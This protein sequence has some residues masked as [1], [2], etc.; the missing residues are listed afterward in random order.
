[1]NRWVGIWLRAWR[2]EPLAF[3]SPLS[4]EVA[5]A[6]LIEGRISH[7]RAAFSFGGG[8]GFT[9]AG[10]VGARRISVQAAKAGIR[11][12]WRPVFRGRLDPTAE[13]GIPGYRPWQQNDS[14]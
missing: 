13:A 12:S 8:G 1:M 14:R 4:A 11:N 9:V 10:H 2:S 7:L 6:R 5:R 3:V